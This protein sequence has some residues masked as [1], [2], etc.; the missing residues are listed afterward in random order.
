MG[1][2]GDYKGSSADVKSGCRGSEHRNILESLSSGTS[3]ST[4]SIGVKALWL[5]SEDSP[6]PWELNMRLVC[7]HRV[8]FPLIALPLAFKKERNS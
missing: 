2:E 5:W 6:M 4:C 1:G 8:I 7:L 3:Q